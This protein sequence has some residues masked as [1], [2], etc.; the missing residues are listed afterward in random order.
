M[1]CAT[2]VADAVSA[3]EL[4]LESLVAAD[5]RVRIAHGIFF[6]LML[7]WS[8]VLLTDGFRVAGTGG[9]PLSSISLTL[10]H[11]RPGAKGSKTTSSSSP[12]ELD[13]PL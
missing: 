4:R 11:I 10:A 7:Y 2:P 9:L 12:R 3:L 13:R 1:D 5:F 8:D 6:F